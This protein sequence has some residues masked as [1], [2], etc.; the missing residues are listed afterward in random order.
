MANT[1]FSP[2]QVSDIKAAYRNASDPKKQIS[3]LADL[4]ATTKEEICKVL[5]IETP[6]PKPKKV[7]RSYDQSVKDSVVKAV[8][9][10]GMTYQQAAER[11]GVPY[12]NVNAWVN[13]ARKKQAEISRFAEEVE[14]EQTAA[15][16]AA[17]EN[18]VKKTANSGS[19]K[20]PPAPFPDERKPLYE[21]VLGEVKEGVD[22]FDTFL[23]GFIGIDIFNE[24]EED[25]LDN[26]SERI[27]GFR[28]GLKTG[29]ELMKEEAKSNARDS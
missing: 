18:K 14:A 2:E 24:S 12:G 6:A 22:G 1:D 8:I 26:L 27:H 19:F 13:K 4:Y 17:P 3:I 5:E 28:D 7:P 21:R 10:D 9:L 11:F 25:M 23:S 29:I 20:K 15:P 16:A